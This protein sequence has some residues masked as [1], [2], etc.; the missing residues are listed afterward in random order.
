MQTCL[1][2]C[3]HVMY[4][5]SVGNYESII[6]PMRCFPTRWIVHSP[7]NDI[8]NGETPCGGLKQSSCDPLPKERALSS[9]AMYCE[10]KATME[11]IV[12]RMSLQSTP[13]FRVAL[14][15][16]DRFYEALNSGRV[17]DFTEFHDPDFP[18]LSQVSSV[19]GA[20]ISQISLADATS[21]ICGDDNE[22][23]DIVATIAATSPTVSPSVERNE[24]DGSVKTTNLDAPC[25]SLPDATEPPADVANSLP[26]ATESTPKTTKR[27]KTSKEAD[28]T[29]TWSFADRPV[30]NGMT[31]AQRKEAQAKKDRQVARQ[32][33]AE[34]R[35]GKMSR[36]V[37]FA[38][39]AALLDGPYSFFD[40]KSMVDALVLPVVEVTGLLSVRQRGAGQE[41]PDIKAVPQLPKVTEA[42]DAIR[43]RQDIDLLAYWPDYGYATFDQLDAMTTLVE[44]RNRFNLVMRTIMW[45]ENLEWRVSDL[46]QPFSDTRAT[47]KVR[48]LDPLSVL[49]CTLTVRCFLCRMS[50]SGTWK[51]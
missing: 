14:K 21:S 34:Y 25:G 18:G 2:P 29:V 47:T 42:I 20:Q 50:T 31:K 1:L 10:A 22:T 36:F 7:E 41:I 28:K 19:G 27:V 35:R 37:T 39:V 12:D 32:L 43:I 8:G 33:A 3:R 26:N 6:P 17:V 11:K 16:L 48:S 24:D 23:S 30:I 40:A 13:T 46:R 45:I 38:E 15:W 5:R 4:V 9:T 49:E 51:R 44:A